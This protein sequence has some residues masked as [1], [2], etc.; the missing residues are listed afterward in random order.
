MLLNKSSKFDV[1]VLVL[2]LLD[3]VAFLVIQVRC[4]Y[5]R[6]LQELIVIILNKV[7]TRFLILL[8][9]LKDWSILIFHVELRLV[10]LIDALLVIL[11]CHLHFIFSLQAFVH[12]FLY[13][14]HSNITLLLAKQS[15]LDL[16]LQLLGLVSQVHVLLLALFV[17]CLLL[18]IVVEELPG[19]VKLLL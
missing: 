12:H 7:D 1:A 9:L 14:L 15:L 13:L 8:D 19:L 5:S 17:L 10:Q 18:V 6:L 16:N 11:E 2:Q 4:E 3:V